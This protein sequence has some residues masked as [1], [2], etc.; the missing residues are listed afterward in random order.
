MTIRTIIAASLFSIGCLHKTYTMDEL[1]SPKYNGITAIKYNGFPAI[2]YDGITAIS[3]QLQFGDLN[4]KE[5]YDTDANGEIDTIRFLETFDQ[6]SRLQIA[7]ID[8]LDPGDGG[9][10]GVLSTYKRVSPDKWRFLNKKD[11]FEWD[12]YSNGSIMVD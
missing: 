11:I 10:L 4:K 2:K 8:Y 3:E 7:V 12:T 1:L 9:R 6:S 5:Y